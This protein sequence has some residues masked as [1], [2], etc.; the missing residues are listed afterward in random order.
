MFSCS[1]LYINATIQVSTLLFSYWLVLS[2]MCGSIYLR[3]QEDAQYNTLNVTLKT[4]EGND[5]ASHVN[6]NA[7]FN[8]RFIAWVNVRR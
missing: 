6:F 3:N 8:K 4:F 1:N 2:D 7:C 5:C